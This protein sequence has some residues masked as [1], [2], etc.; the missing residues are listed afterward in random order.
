MYEKH[1]NVIIALF[2][3]SILLNIFLLCC[4]TGNDD[5]GGSGTVSYR[6]ERIGDI[7]QKQDTTLREAKDTNREI[8]DTTRKLSEIEQSDGARI[9]ELKR[10]LQGVQQRMQK[11]TP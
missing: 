8:R 6:S 3:C 11:E 9:A 7:Q 10:I 1:P 5:K 2:V 4:N